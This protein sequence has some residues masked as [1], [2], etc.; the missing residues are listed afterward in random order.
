MWQEAHDLYVAVSEAPNITESW[1]RGVLGG[2]AVSAA[3]LALLAWRQGNSQKSREWL[4]EANAA[5]DASNDTETLEYL[6][7]VKARIEN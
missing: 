1:R 6:R 5:A 3:R 2:V 7:E 4:S